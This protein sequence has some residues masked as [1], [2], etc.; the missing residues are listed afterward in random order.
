[1]GGLPL[2]RFTC[3]Y[4]YISATGLK[5]M[6]IVSIVITLRYFSKLSFPK[7]DFEK[8]NLE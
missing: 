8:K 6:D 1:M 7:L 5:F 3:N 2:N 4:I